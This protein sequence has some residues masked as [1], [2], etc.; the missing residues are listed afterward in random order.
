M[1]Q[2]ERDAIT[3]LTGRTQCCK[4]C[5]QISHMTTAI[6]ISDLVQVFLWRQIISWLDLTGP[7]RPFIQSQSLFCSHVNIIKEFSHY[8]ESGNTPHFKH[9]KHTE[10]RDIGTDSKRSKEK[11]NGI[12]LNTPP[13]PTPRHTHTFPLPPHLNDGLTKSDRENMG[14]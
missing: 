8:L 14:Q 11:K 7:W 1:W 5:R 10:N 9:N 3:V 2:V 6:I 12:T 13:P 4:N